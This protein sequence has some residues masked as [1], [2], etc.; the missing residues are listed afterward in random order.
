ML[1]GRTVL[2]LILGHA[3]QKSANEVNYLKRRCLLIGLIFSIYYYVLVTIIMH[4]EGL[5]HASI[6]LVT[7]ISSEQC[8]QFVSFRLQHLQNWLTKRPVSKQ[9]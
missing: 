7:L 2:Y 5:L 3:F 6:C 8:S 4:V 1:H 9:N